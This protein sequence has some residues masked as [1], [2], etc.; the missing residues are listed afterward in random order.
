[1]L[2]GSGVGVG[3]VVLFDVHAVAYAVIDGSSLSRGEKHKTPL[4]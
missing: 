2:A 1:M 4:I 3:V